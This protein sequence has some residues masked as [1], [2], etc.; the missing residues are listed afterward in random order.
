MMFIDSKTHNLNGELNETSTLYKNCQGRILRLIEA[1]AN[2]KFNPILC[3]QKQFVV[4]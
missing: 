4:A 3:I 1:L 2:R